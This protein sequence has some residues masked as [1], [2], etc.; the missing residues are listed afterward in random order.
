VIC[1]A[2]VELNHHIE[3]HSISA[4]TMKRPTHVL[5]VAL[6]ALLF[7]TSCAKKSETTYTDS[8]NSATSTVTPAPTDSSHA[9]TPTT[10]PL[11][12]ANILASLIEADS[13]EVA[14]GKLVSGKTKNSA[15]KGFAQEMI[16][17]HSKLM[18]DAKALAKKLNVTPAAPANDPHPAELSQWMST[19]GGADAASLD[20]VYMNHMVEDHS[21]DIQEVQDMQSKAQSADL[22]A[23]IDKGLPV[24]KKHLADAQAVVKK[25][26]SK[27][28]A[29]K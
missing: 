14:Q 10:P 9:M 28:T 26:E 13:G 15:V 23:A 29:K 27:M 11:S 8:S 2:E 18:A 24:L 25:L 22:K 7:V 17:D 5:G 16:R 1:H 4:I 21:K 19:L 12:D 6:L 20:S 3:K